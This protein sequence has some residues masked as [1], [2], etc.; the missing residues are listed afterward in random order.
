MKSLGSQPLLDGRE[1]CGQTVSPGPDFSE[2]RFLCIVSVVRQPPL[3][4]G[5]VACNSPIITSSRF[6]TS[7]TVEKKICLLSSIPSKSF[8]HVTLAQFGSPYHPGSVIGQ[9]VYNAL[10]SWKQTTHLLLKLDWE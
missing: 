6:K 2:L 7:S 10:I 9:W 1:E 5:K 4:V 3:W 8:Y